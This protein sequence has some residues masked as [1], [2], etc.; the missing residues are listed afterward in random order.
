MYE[1]LR[2]MYM[3]NARYTPGTVVWCIDDMISRTKTP[4]VLASLGDLRLRVDTIITNNNLGLDDKMAGV[5]SDASKELVD[6]SL[7]AYETFILHKNK[8]REITHKN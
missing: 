4:E 8:F 6:I 7:S 3:E 2:D 5:T 1:L